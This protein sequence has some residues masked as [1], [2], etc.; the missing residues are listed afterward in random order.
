MANFDGP[1]LLRVPT[2]ITQ[3]LSK[4]KISVFAVDQYQKMANFECLIL[5]KIQSLTFQNSHFLFF[6]IFFK[7]W[8]I[9]GSLKLAEIETLENKTWVLYVLSP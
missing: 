1:I 7:N 5:P 8:T 4:F 2:L 9:F 6:F 3:I